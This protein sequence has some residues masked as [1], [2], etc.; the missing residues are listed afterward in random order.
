MQHDNATEENWNYIEGKQKRY[1]GLYEALYNSNFITNNNFKVMDIGCG[2]CSTLYNV[3][4]Q[5]KQYGANIECNGVEHNK[6]IINLFQK[7]LYN[8]WD[9]TKLSLFTQDLF[10]HNYSEYDLILSY[11]PLK[12][13]IDQE[14]MYSKIFNEMKP[15]ALFHEHYGEGKGKD[16]LLLNMDKKINIKPIELLFGGRVN[17]LFLKE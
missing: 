12:K 13:P 1:Y 14:K 17:Y 9:N 2:A 6:E 16:D 5:F 3:S 8:L 10:E 11:L 7:Y 15:G 4:R